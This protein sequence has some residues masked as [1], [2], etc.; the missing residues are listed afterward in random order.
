V[1]RPPLVA[2]TVA[3]I[4]LG[5]G[6]LLAFEH[7][8]TLAVGVLLLLAFIVMGVFLIADPGYLAARPEERE[9]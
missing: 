4:V 6:L 2:W 5:S 1:R 3:A 7:P 8:V 9:E